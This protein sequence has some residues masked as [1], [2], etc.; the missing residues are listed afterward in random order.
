[1]FYLKFTDIYVQVRS[2]EEGW[3]RADSTVINQ[4]AEWDNVS[5]HKLRAVKTQI[6]AMNPMLQMDDIS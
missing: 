4:K 2:E 5:F 3:K 6:A 1:M